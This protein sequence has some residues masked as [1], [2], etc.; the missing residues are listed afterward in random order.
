MSEE[1]IVGTSKVDKRYRVTLTKPIPK[2]LKIGPGD[3]IIFKR[4]SN[5]RIYLEPSRIVKI[6]KKAVKETEE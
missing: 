2:L 6:V 4:T 3:L 5:G 1:I